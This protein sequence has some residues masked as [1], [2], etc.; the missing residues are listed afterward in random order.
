M[1]FPILYLHHFFRIQPD[2]TF[3]RIAQPLSLI[4]NDVADRSPIIWL[5]TVDIKNY[6]DKFFEVFFLFLLSILVQLL[7]AWNKWTTNSHLLHA[8][9]DKKTPW[10]VPQMPSF[11]SKRVSCVFHSTRPPNGTWALCRVS[12][13]QREVVLIVIS[14][15]RASRAKYK[16][17]KKLIA[18]GIFWSN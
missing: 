13:S 17:L 4:N 1:N 6:I 10:T 18:L 5:S 12:Q 8:G 2:H 3:S 11:E 7:Y 16:Y 9:W 15:C 14:C